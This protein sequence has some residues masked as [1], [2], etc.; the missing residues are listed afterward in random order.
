LGVWGASTSGATFSNI[1]SMAAVTSGV[2]SNNVMVIDVPVTPATPWLKVSG[3]SVLST[4]INASAIVEL[5]ASVSRPKT[6]LA[7]QVVV[8]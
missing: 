4:A 7:Q 6:S 5:Y 1:T 3:G 2:L 8:A